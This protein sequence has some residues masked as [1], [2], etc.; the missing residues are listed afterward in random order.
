MLGCVGCA[1]LLA[2]IVVLAVANGADGPTTNSRLRA[3]NDVAITAC[4]SGGSLV[5]PQADVKVTNSGSRAATYTVT[6]VFESGAT[7]W[8]SGVAIFNDL[9]PGQT[10][11]ERASAFGA[12]AASD[13]TCRVSD[14]SRF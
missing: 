7:R 8:G 13:F 2:V 3:A 12:A 5:G 4:K 10:Q 9:G 14:V 1:I 6:V 11:T